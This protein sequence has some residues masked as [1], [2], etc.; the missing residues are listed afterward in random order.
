MNTVLQWASNYSI[1]VLVLLSSL[2]ALIY[3]LQLVTGQAVKSQFD[4]YLKELE[5]RLE[6]RLDFEQYV[7]LER[8]KLTCEFAQRLSQIMTNLN[9]HRHGQEVENLYWFRLD[10]SGFGKWVSGHWSTGDMG[11]WGTSAL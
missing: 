10:A 7:L 5:L 4:R 6:R 9:R 1:P 2:A 3:V 8:Y 11:H